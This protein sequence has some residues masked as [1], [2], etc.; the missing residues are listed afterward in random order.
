MAE[1]NALALLIAH[2]RSLITFSAVTFA[3]EAFDSQ[4]NYKNSSDTLFRLL[5]AYLTP[6]DPPPPV[7]AKG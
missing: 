7:P 2:H 5:G 3:P 6:D 4:G 1:I